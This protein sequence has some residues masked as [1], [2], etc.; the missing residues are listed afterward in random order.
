MSPTPITD[1]LVVGATG[2]IG[3]LAVAASIRQGHRTRAL[4]RDPRRGA[5]LPAEARAV[6]GDLT[7]ADTLTEAVAGVDAVVFTHGSHGGAAEAEAVDY[8][9]VRN[10]LAALGDAPARIALMT[11]IGVT[12]HTPGARL[13]APR[14]AAG[15]RQRPGVHDRAARLVRR[16]RRRPAEPGHA[17]GR[18]PVGRQPGRRGGVAPPDRPSAHHEPHLRRRRPEDPRARCRAR[19]RPDQPGPAVRRAAGRPRRRPRRRP[20]HR[21]HAAGRRAQPGARRARCRTRPPWLTTRLR[22]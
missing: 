15:A 2:S 12:K 4:V 3:A 8:G 13:E 9:A 10:V 18:P 14:E 11:T 20:G 5:S 6:I 19:P 17:A 7:R 16:Q 21:Q 22:R 1:V